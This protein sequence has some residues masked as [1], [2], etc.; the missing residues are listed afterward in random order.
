M[1]TTANAGAFAWISARPSGHGM[2]RAH[3]EAAA[4]HGLAQAQR[5]GPVVIDQHQ[6]AVFGQFVG[7]ESEI[8]SQ[9]GVSTIRAL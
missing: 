5:E 9:V 1:S 3:L 2:G 6:R 8:F 4:F 7:F